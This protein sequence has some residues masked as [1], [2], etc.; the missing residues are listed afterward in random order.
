LRDVAPTIADIAAFRRP[1]PNVR[2][3]RP[4]DGVSSGSDPPRLILE[5]VWKGVGSGDLEAAAGEWPFLD[6]LLR[7]GAGTLDGRVGF[8]PL[9]P[10][11]A[12]ATLGTGGLPREHGITGTLVRDG[13]RV[14]RAWSPDAPFSVIS[15]LPDDL[16]EVL[17][18]RPRIGLVGI[19]PADRGIIGGNWYLRNDRDDVSFRSGE[20][21]SQAATA[22][23]LLERRYGTDDIPDLMAVVMRGRLAALDSGLRRL[24]RTA[25]RVSG[26]SVLVVVTATGSES[27]RR[28]SFAAS[29]LRAEVEGILGQ[30][31]IDS[32]VVGGLFVDQTA[33]ADSGTTDE[34]ILGALRAVRTARGERVLADVFPGLAISLARYC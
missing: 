14:V 33:V 2:S 32:L 4:V 21:K 30:T 16:D 24:M 23:E 10:A 15:T 29:R 8:L 31:L 19:D 9:D 3:G 6:S 22:S 1:H 20:P 25:T 34:Q 28:S 18:R 13:D 17:A 26:G 12:L 27:P 7:R 11:A 5:V